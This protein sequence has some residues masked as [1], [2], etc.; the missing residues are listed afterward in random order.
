MQVPSGDPAVL[1]AVTAVRLDPAQVRFRVGYDSITPHL[2]A[3]WC[4]TPGV[5]VAVN[6]GFFNSDYHATALV[7]RGGVA[8]G[9]SYQGQ[10]GMFA[11]D[12][13]GQVALRHLASAPYA[14]GE[15][16]T[17]ALQGWPMLVA[18]GQAVYANPDNT[19]G[20]RRTVLARDRSGRVLLLVFATSHFALHDLP[21]WL[22]ASDMDI[23]SAVNLDGGSSSALCVRGDASV[24]LEAYTPLPLVLLVEPRS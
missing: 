18:G 22:L 20:A 7:I 23:D 2:I 8:S 10:G 9:T 24:L 14:P 11:V 4:A 17:E 13:A 12:S 21:P 15:S 5:V 6:G 3:A 16:L 1:A 19:E